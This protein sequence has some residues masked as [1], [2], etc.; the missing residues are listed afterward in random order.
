MNV[1]KE[2][3]EKGKVDFKF[4]PENPTESE[5][6][7]FIKLEKPP[8]PED[9]TEVQEES[10][11]KDV[12]V[13]TDKIINNK[14]LTIY[15]RQTSNEKD[16]KIG[17]WHTF[18][19]FDDKKRLLKETAQKLLAG[20]EKQVSIMHQYDDEKGTH[21]K[22]NKIESGDNQGEETETI[23]GSWKEIGKDQRVAE[24][25]TKLITKGAKSKHPEGTLDRKIKFQEYKQ[26]NNQEK[27]KWMWVGDYNTKT[28][29]GD[30]EKYN[31]S[32]FDKNLPDWAWHYLT[33]LGFEKPTQEKR[34]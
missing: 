19:E 14:G 28:L 8:V 22:N 13:I 1:E 4:P 7:K 32:N 20:Q 5:I 34:E 23:E 33:S 21:T 24:E 12:H 18:S 16:K 9:G 30:Q 31:P 27:K 15:E 26:E 10:D 29:P 11:K 2:D 25:T 17:D 6:P 3:S